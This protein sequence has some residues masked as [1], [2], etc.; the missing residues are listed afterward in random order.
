[1]GVSGEIEE[2]PALSEAEQENSFEEAAIPPEISAKAAALLVADSRELLYGK[3]ERER[4]SM[5]STTKI[6]TALLALEAGMPLWEIRVTEAMLRVEGTS[7]G[8]RAGDSVTLSGLVYGMLLKS[9]NDAAN[10]AAFAL[11]GSLEKFAGGMNA[12]AQELGMRDTHF[13]T[14][15][16]LDDPEH[17][18]T[19]YDM[20]LLGCAALENPEF[21]R[22]CALRIAQVRF[23]N[24]PYLRTLSNHN[25][26][27]KTY[28]GGSGIKTGFTK[29]SG[30]CLVSAATRNGVTLVAV[31]LSAPDDW[32]DHGKLLDYGFSLVRSYMLDGDVSGIRLPVAGGEQASV[33]LRCAQKPLC[34]ALKEPEDLRREICLKRFEYAPLEAGRI[35]GEA[36]YIQDGKV[37]CAV[38]LVTA[39]AVAVAQKLLP[40]NEEE[41]QLKKDSLLE[42]CRRLF[43]GRVGD[44][45]LCVP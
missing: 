31:T 11:T 20:A 23:G 4:R 24:P 14:P 37:V 27:L 33:G 43:R 18:S 19:A 8:L 26:I 12:R 10:A 35:A 32:A 6:M 41:K 28:A 45:V 39:E 22:V 16:G 13:V 29:K 17:Y 25:R 21:A 44:A 7:M 36:R 38:P 34:A 15:S 2:P 30:R 42:K 5:A 40:E 1:L 9:G 3:N